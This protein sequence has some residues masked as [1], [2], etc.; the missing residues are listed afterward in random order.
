MTF[1]T[2]LA[3][4]MTLLAPCS[5]AVSAEDGSGAAALAGWFQTHPKAV[6]Y[7][8]I[9][10]DLGSLFAAAERAAVPQTFLTEQLDEAYAKSVPPAL[11]LP[12]LAAR[13]A[14]LVSLKKTLADQQPCPGTTAT[15]DDEQAARLRQL[16]LI[17]RRGVPLPVIEGV[18]AD[19][20]AGRKDF[21]AAL[22]ALR[23]IAN[24]PSL[25]ELPGEKM[26]ALGKAIL[27]SALSPA[28]Y[29]AL[30]SFYIKGRMKNLNTREITDIILAAL[31]DGKGI[32]RIEQE[33]ERRRKP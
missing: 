26:S 33:L 5:L 10:D 11:V 17:R 22:D 9:R 16:S 18:L 30:S 31:G 19:A 15:G 12:A 13:L 7:E 3:L 32:I 23:T 6:Q 4:I 25:G 1:L 2:R 14:D 28:G 29:T 8:T 24:I 27:S 20:C 21:T